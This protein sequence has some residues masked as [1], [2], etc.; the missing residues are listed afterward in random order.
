MD[1]ASLHLFLRIADLGSVS[2]AARDL[3]LSPASASARLAKLEEIIGFRLFN[4]T[5]RAVSLTTD[6]AEFLPYAQQVL[7]TLQTGIGAVS[8][9]GAAA[10]GLLRMTMPGSFGRMH[11]VPALAEFQ[12]RHPLVS[13]D[14]RLSDEVLDVVEGA[15]D[16]IIRNAP[17]AD[18]T[19]VARK[20]AS[21]QRLLVASADYIERR[22]A[23]TTPDELSEHRCIVL[24]DHNKW[25]FKT[26]RIVS[27][28]R[29][30]VVN[31]GEAMRTLIESGMGIGIQS[32]WIASEHLKSGRLVQVL[33]DHPLATDSALWALYPSN[34]IVAPKV[35]A[36]IDFLL[37][38]FQPVP[39]WER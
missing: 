35:R 19:L 6:G 7:E 11:I 38:R 29:S 20:L 4:R 14:L 18:S 32:L 30:I 13:L 10:Q 16:L 5:T 36:M 3:S 21:D 28:P 15:Y 2:A 12:A 27:V 34:R 26:A 9:Q 25:K 17:L 37:E 24:A 22:G 8:G 31:D 23:P 33:P 39:P 1:T